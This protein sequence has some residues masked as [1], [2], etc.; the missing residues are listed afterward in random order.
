MVGRKLATGWEENEAYCVVSSGVALAGRASSGII[1]GAGNSYLKRLCPGTAMNY[2]QCPAGGALQ[3]PVCKY[4]EGHLVSTLTGRPL[5]AEETLFYPDG[6]SCTWI[7]AELPV[8]T[9]MVSSSWEGHLHLLLLPSASRA[10][11]KWNSG[12]WCLATTKSFPGGE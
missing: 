12:D 10:V 8:T 6:L 11:L 2:P 1:S 3:T 9:Q 7:K 4:T 5:V